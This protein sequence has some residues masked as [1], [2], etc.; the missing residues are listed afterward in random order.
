MKDDQRPCVEAMEAVIAGT[1]YCLERIR[2]QQLVPSSA[3][4]S[5]Y[6]I[7]MSQAKK[8]REGQLEVSAH[9]LAALDWDRL[10]ADKEATRINRNRHRNHRRNCLK[11]GQYVVAGVTSSPLRGVGGGGVCFVR[12]SQRVSI[13]FLAS[14]QGETTRQEF[15]T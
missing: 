15:T 12:R 9:Q 4:P 13:W 10:K 3:D 8:I 5:T 1:A 2:N 14:R 6:E 11:A 7:Q